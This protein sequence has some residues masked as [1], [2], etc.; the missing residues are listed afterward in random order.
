MFFRWWLVVKL[1]VPKKPA[2]SV[3]VYHEKGGNKFVWN[4][5]AY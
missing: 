3:F 5:D 2:A 1:G 4:N